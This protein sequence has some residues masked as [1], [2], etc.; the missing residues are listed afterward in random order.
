[1]DRTNYFTKNCVCVSVC[2]RQSR[3]FSLQ[4]FLKHSYKTSPMKLFRLL[5]NFWF[6]LRPGDKINYCQGMKSMYCNRA[7][8]KWLHWTIIAVAFVIY[9]SIYKWIFQKELNTSKTTGTTGKTFTNFKSM[10]GNKKQLKLRVATDTFLF[11]NTFFNTFLL[12]FHM[13]MLVRRCINFDRT[14]A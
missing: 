8:F 10:F 1:M 12:P 7:F 14:C 5:F 11:F 4:F 9:F 13:R 6:L 3:L 2:N